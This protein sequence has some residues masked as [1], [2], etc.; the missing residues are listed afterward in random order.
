G[1]VYAYLK[2][3]EATA[4]RAIAESAQKAAETQ[5]EIADQQRVIA[6]TQEKEAERLAAQNASLLNIL[7][8]YVTSTIP[9]DM[10]AKVDREIEG[11]L[12]GRAR[13][14]SVSHALNLPWYLAGIIHGVET[15]FDF[16]THL[17]NGDP[18]T[19]RTVH[20]PSG[21]PLEGNPPFS[22]EE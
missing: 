13:Y 2:Q 16:R 18:L 21:R 22:W 1:W 3:R 19:A 11:L 12:V 17:H 14:E 7:D 5:K 9:P 8:L 6:E 10:E 20:V 4:Q 15:G